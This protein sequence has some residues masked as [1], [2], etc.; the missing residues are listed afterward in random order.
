[1]EIIS[2]VLPQGIVIRSE[3]GTLKF[4]SQFHFPRS[5][6]NCTF[7]FFFLIFIFI[8]LAVTRVLVASLIFTETR[9]IFS[10]DLWDLVPWWDQS[11]APL[12]W[13]H[14]VL[15]TGLSIRAPLYLYLN[16]L[17]ESDNSQM[18]TVTQSS[19]ECRLHLPT[20]FWISYKHPSLNQ[21]LL[22]LHRRHSTM[23]EL[24]WTE[25]IKNPNE[26]N[27]VFSSFHLF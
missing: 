17:V 3:V 20:A 1:M 27:E 11:Q 21:S 15:A 12:H 14:W 24:N 18:Y 2:S 8:C 23:F 9:K 6:C 5:N 19:P 22:P 13:E 10:C 7:I 25:R 4:E 26:C 16:Y